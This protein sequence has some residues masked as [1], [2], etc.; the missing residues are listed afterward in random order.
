MF[1]VKFPDV[2]ILDGA[3][4]ASPA[5]LQGHM[6]TFPVRRSRGEMYVVHGRL[7]V[8]PSPH[9]HTTAQTRM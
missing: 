3:C 4:G 2:V 9:S 8:C 7:C 5:G 1:I 6:I